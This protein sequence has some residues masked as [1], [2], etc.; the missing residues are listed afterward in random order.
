MIKIQF[1]LKYRKIDGKE[2]IYQKG[3]MEWKQLS[4]FLQVKV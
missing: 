4:I 2:K 3:E 1:R